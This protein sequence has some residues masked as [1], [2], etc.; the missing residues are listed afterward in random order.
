MRLG[1]TITFLV[2]ACF[3]PLASSREKQCQSTAEAIPLC[4]VLSNATK[5][6]G[7]DIT[8]KGVYYRVIHGSILTESACEKTKVN[9]RLAS[10]WKANKHALSILNSRARNNQGT[11][12]ALRGT[13]RVAQD[14]CFGQTCTLYE[15]EEHE[16]LCAE[17]TK[18]VNPPNTV[19]PKGAS[20]PLT[21]SPT[22]TM[23]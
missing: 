18:S 6:D 12:I 13:F 5:Y 3:A 14:G 21:D 10:D 19:N 23:R 1:T 8:V 4:S 9:M 17:P 15:I 7:K 2:A 16:L 20:K 11:D 22:T